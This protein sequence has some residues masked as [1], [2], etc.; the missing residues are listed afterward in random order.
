VDATTGIWP[1]GARVPIGNHPGV[2][3]GDSNILIAGS[4][5]CSALAGAPPLSDAQWV[6]VN[7]L[8]GAPPI[9]G[10]APTVVQARH[11]TQYAHDDLGFGLQ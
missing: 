6:L 2:G 3:A 8:L 5:I 9:G 4:L 7:W 11:M 1:D 10:K